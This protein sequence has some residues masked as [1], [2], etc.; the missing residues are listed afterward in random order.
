MKQIFTF[1]ILGLGVC[2]GVQAQVDAVQKLDAV[3]LSDSKLKNYAAGIKIEKLTDSVLSNNAT[4]LTN[5]LAFNSNIY[6][7]ENGAGM[8]SSP[9]FRGT[10]ASQTAVI[11]NGININSQLNGQTD[12]NTVNT[13]NYSSIDIRSGG[14]SVQYGSGSIGGS[15]HLNNDLKFSNHAETRIKTGYGSFNSKNLGI[16]SSF[17]SEAWTANIGV[18]YV[19]SDN[20]YKYLGTDSV[21]ENG[22]FHNLNMNV[23]LGVFISDKDILKL[24]HQSYFGERN[25]SGTLVGPSRSKYEDENFRSMLEW[26]RIIGKFSSRLKVAHLHEMFK[27]FENKDKDNYSL[28]KVNTLL[29]NHSFNVS[30]N[31]K[32]QFK[33]ILEYSNS[34][35]NGDSFKE[36]VRN[37]FSTT[38]L[39]NHKPNNSISY[40][41]NLRQDFTT[42]GERPF[43]FSVDAGFDLFEHYQ[44]Q[45]NGSKN[46][47]IPTFND[48]YWQPGGNLDLVPESSYQI[49]LGQN[50]N[51]PNFN[52]KLN[53]YYINTEDMIQWQPNSTGLWSPINIGEVASYG[54]EVEVKSHYNINE[55]QFNVSGHYSYTVSEDLETNKQL[56]YV[57]FHKGN[58]ALAYNYKAVTVFYQHMFNGDVFTTADNLEGRFTSLNG[59][60]MG[61]MGCNYTFFKNTKNE[62]KAGITL[63]NIFNE[64]YENVAFRPMPNRNFNIQINYKF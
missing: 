12:F 60:D 14:G 22:E 6:F 62:L 40:G 26:S 20:D 11:W 1:L 39:L 5:L 38:A 31:E 61:N 45:I 59:Y 63:K 48:L 51:Y 3:I 18:D 49:D 4:P 64:V 56:I 57:P 43:V 13:S 50:F 30:F 8:V 47:R 23:N 21:N 33:T 37:V 53:G 24:Y 46:Y 2:S 52:V 41:V 42:G 9:S 34:K 28:G 55:H 17:G 58:L 15:I 27:Y 7:K 32:L 35:G 36:P 44:I 25:F 54:A 10:T 16:N 19:D 29:I